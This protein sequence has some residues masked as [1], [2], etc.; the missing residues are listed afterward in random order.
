MVQIYTTRILFSLVL[1]LLYESIYV[2]IKPL[3]AV[4]WR[5]MDRK[6]ER[7]KRLHDPPCKHP[8]HW[9]AACFISIKTAGLA[10]TCQ[11]HHPQAHLHLPNLR[12]LPSQP[13]LLTSEELKRS[14][15]WLT[16]FSVLLPVGSPIRKPFRFTSMLCS[17]KTETTVTY[18]CSFKWSEK[19]LFWTFCFESNK[20]SF[21]QKSALF[22]R[23]PSE[24]QIFK[25]PWFHC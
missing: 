9:G 3:G 16:F 7:C 6:H 4:R 13:S 8:G 2:K 1:A 22:H 14:I 11:N 20:K 15:N 25:K 23:N 10:V 17:F 19:K 18:A 24:R 21:H 5:M 12:L